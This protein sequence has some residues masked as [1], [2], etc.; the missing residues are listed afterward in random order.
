MQC[1][2][3]SQERD[4]KPQKISPRNERFPCLR[5]ARLQTSVFER[6]GILELKF[7]SLFAA[8]STG[9][10]VEALVEAV[11]RGS[12][13][14]LDEPLPVTHVVQAQLLGNLC[15][16][17]GIRKILLIC[18]YENK[19]IAHLILI[20]HFHELLACIFNT[21]AIVAVDDKDEP[22]CALVIVAPQRADLVLATHIPH[23]EANVLVLDCLH[24]EANRRDSCDD[25]A[26]L[27]LV[28]DGS[29]TCGV[30]ANHQDP[31]LL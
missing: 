11:S 31:H 30:E 6:I 16:S 21:V 12:T 18:K 28:E 22:L 5:W 4:C 1:V 25:L 9:Q 27:E 26:K 3:N 10:P 7:L 29:L 20:Q 13:C 8:E 15:C 24:I 2:L 17:H 19:C 23:C 14:R